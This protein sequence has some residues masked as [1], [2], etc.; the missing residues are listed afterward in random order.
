VLSPCGGLE[1]SPSAMME[2]ALELG[3]D[4]IAVT[5]HNSL[6]NASV[7]REAAVE[8]GL[9]FIYGVEVQTSEEVHVVVLFDDYGPAR[10]FDE[11]LYASL[12]PVDNDPEYFGDQVVVD[13]D[14]NIIRFEKRA[15]INS[16]TWSFEETFDMVSK[17]K[18][19]AFP[20]HVNSSSYSVIRQLGFIPRHSSLCSVEITSGTDPAEVIKE[21][22]FL[23]EYAILKNSDAHYLIDMGVGYTEFYI[24]EP[25]LSEVMLACQKSSGRS[26]RVS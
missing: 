3:I 1:M 23:K 24:K 12:L 2:R 4:I 13:I 25:T 6:A 7:Y 21:Y 17:F 9:V 19:F 15:L 11:L 14:E 8:R 10:E 5:D 18:G 20:A 26:L 16:S 22:P